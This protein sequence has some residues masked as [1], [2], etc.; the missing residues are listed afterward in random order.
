[1]VYVIEGISG[2]YDEVATY[3]IGYKLTE[4]EAKEIVEQLIKQERE[5][6]SY[7]KGRPYVEIVAYLEENPPLDPL[8]HYD[9]AGTDYQYYE[10]PYI[11]G[12]NW[13]SELRKFYFEEEGEE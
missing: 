8:Y 11:T 13:A 6:R 12:E 4:K 7:C 9:S 10:C 5:I 1:M 2:E 3:I